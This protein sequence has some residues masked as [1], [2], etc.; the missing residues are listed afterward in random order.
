MTSEDGSRETVADI[1]GRARNELLDLGLRNPL[2]SYREL[3]ARG[4]DFPRRATAHLSS[5]GSWSSSAQSRQSR[6]RRLRRRCA[7]RRTTRPDEDEPIEP[8]GY[9]RLETTHTAEQLD[10]RL[11]ASYYAARTYMDDQGVNIL[12]V[13]IGMLRWL[14]SEDASQERLA[15]LVLVPVELDR[16]DAKH[17]FRIAYSDE[18]LEDNVSLSRKLSEEFGIRLPP[19]FGGET[20][21]P[22][23]LDLEA[24]FDDVE[25]AVSDMGSWSVDRQAAC[26]GFFSFGKFRMFKDLDLSLWPDSC[27]PALHPVLAGLLSETEGLPGHDALPA[28]DADID[29]LV[30]PQECHQVI[31]ADSSQVRAILAVNGGAHLVV[32]GPPGTGKSQTITNI[33]AEAI[34]NGRTVLFVAEK[35]A[36]LSVVKRNLDRVGLGD[37]CLELHSNKTKRKTV[38]R[39]L[40]RTMESARQAQPPE[41]IDVSLLREQRD[42]LNRYARDLHA[43]IGDDAGHPV[44]GAGRSR[45][46]AGGA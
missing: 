26:L 43:P 1:L 18:K 30:D 35:M 4:V 44:P 16:Q 33:I 11:L 29:D 19:L 25:E 39:E 27:D 41:A 31:E 38:L 17:R 8:A 34:G 13:A 7:T 3:R 2:I 12:F 14:E 9:A 23:E 32:R 45:A 21:G 36:A 37:A 40:A 15:P 6:L 42:Q 22:E 10:K 46:P 5:N 24:Y 20:Q 28:E